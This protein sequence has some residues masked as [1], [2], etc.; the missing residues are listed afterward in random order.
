[1]ITSLD[2]RSTEVIRAILGE[3]FPDLD[4]SRARLLLAGTGSD[5]WVV[6]RA[7]VKIPRN[8]EGERRLMVEVAAHPA[9]AERLGA[10]VP[11]IVAVA[12]PS[13]RLPFAAAVYA[14][15]RGRQGQTNDGP[16]IQPKAWARTTLAQELAQTLT[17]LHATSLGSIRATGIVPRHPVLDPQIDVGESTIAWARRVAGDA[18]DVFLSDPLPAE[19]REA[20]PG[21]LCH[22][23]LKGEHLFVSEDGTRLTAIIDWSDAAIA[24][25]ACDLAGLA[26]WL[27]PGFVR[28]VLR[29]YG[30]SADEGTYHRAVF[31]ARAGLLGFMEH[32]LTAGA[33][34]VPVALVDAQLRA[35]FRE[36]M[37]PRR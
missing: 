2:T 7:V 33:H 23:D 14:R 16:I 4:V 18:V 36:E 10:L 15:A 3:A 31:L 20:G 11:A 34:R 17:I 29:H 21:V 27:G 28:E 19:A 9:I 26:I 32:E 35:A 13:E 6:G 25:P 12:E 22:A 30:G 24:D 1:M 8:S 5:T 37:P